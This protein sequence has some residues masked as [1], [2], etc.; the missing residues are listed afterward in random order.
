MNE[1]ASGVGSFIWRSALDIGLAG[2]KAAQCS[3][4]ATHQSLGYSTAALLLLVAAVALRRF[5]RWA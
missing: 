3:N 5:G 1:R 2:A 4:A